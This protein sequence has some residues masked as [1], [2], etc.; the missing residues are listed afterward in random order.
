MYANNILKACLS[1]KNADPVKESG[2]AL[3]LLNLMK[4]SNGQ[5]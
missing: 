4:L 5:W 1:L 2:L 3:D